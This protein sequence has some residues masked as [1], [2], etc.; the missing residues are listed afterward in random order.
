M[1]KKEGKRKKRKKRENKKETQKS[2]S[3]RI[4][5]EKNSEGFFAG[6]SLIIPVPK[7]RHRTKP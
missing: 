1:K 6:Y 5:K 2:G 3:H 7:K 4:A